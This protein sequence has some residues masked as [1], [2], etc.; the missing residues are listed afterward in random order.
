V[1]QSRNQNLKKKGVRLWALEIEGDVS[2]LDFSPDDHRTALGYDDGHVQLIDPTGTPD[3]EFNLGP[4]V[5]Q[6][7]I[8]PLKKRVIALDEYSKL[9]G[10]DYAG[11]QKF[12]K[13]YDGVWMSFEVKS[14]VIYLYSW[15]KDAVKVDSSGRVKGNFFL[16]ASR[17][18]I[19]VVPKKDQIWVVHNQISL[20]LYKSNG[21]NLWM[22]N[23][24]SVIDLSR[25]SLADMVV[26]D[27]GDV[28]AVCCH[29]KGVYVFNGNDHTLKHIDL[30]RI[31]THV[32]VSGNGEYLLL[33][34]ALQKVYMVDRE[35]RVVWEHKLE[36]NAEFLRLD[37]R[38]D[39]VLILEENG[40]LACHKFARDHERRRD[41][42]ELTSFGEVSDKKE[43][44]KLPVPQRVTRQSPFVDISDYGSHFLFGGR[45]E[46][47]LY[48]SAGRQVWFKTFLIGMD[49]VFLSRDGRT[50]LMSNKN[51]I[52]VVHSEPY[53]ES[54]VVSY[55]YDIRAIGMDPM[56]AAFMTYDS[57][58]WVTLY[59]GT[60]KKIW[61]RNL[62]MKVSDILLDHRL[63]IA[64]LR[65]TSKVLYVLD[66]KTMKARQ[67]F[68][69]EKINSWALDKAGVFVGGSDGGCYRF[70]L[71]GSKQWKFKMKQSVDAIILLQRHVGFRDRGN[72]LLLFEKMGFQPDEYVLHHSGSVLTQ[73]EKETLEIVP[74]RDSI[75]CYKVFSGDL[76]WKMSMSRAVQDL[77]VSRE[78]NRMVVLDSR[79]FHYHQLISDPVTQ[80]DRSS[81]LEF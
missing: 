78:A 32:T 71:D 5:R 10:F 48:D 19:R 3:W 79:F 74:V 26:S 45:K 15:K 29:N 34:D 57:S 68:V 13:D 65:A 61:S 58:K 38:G 63:K 47:R 17:R 12:R 64:I 24:P 20:G 6:V 41:Y 52:Y 40:V 4:P 60:G 9:S 75:S 42:L 8:L 66:L 14:G 46:F 31:V 50:T 36:S 59:S 51:E 76:V 1:A 23:C 44:W 43:I 49:H 28:M 7:K 54:Q 30:D 69:G 77:A 18:M 70:N 22:V 56:G 25:E 2:C 35:A 33:S 53:K 37:R 81:F 72:A 55:H 11:Q 16:P 21:A 80:E 67:I 73:W 62:Q 39:R 27:S